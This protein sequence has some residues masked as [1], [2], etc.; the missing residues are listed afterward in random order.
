[1]TDLTKINGIGKSSADKIVAAGFADTEALAALEGDFSALE[2]VLQ[3]PQIES[4]S[5]HFALESGQ[6]VSVSEDEVTAA[7][8]NEPVA[9]TENASS[10]PSTSMDEENSSN[11]SEE[12]P[13]DDLGNEEDVTSDAPA[14]NVDVSDTEEPKTEELKVPVP[15]PVPGTGQVIKF[16]ITSGPFAKRTFEWT[17]FNPSGRW[18]EDGNYVSLATV[19]LKE[20]SRDEEV[21][22]FH[23]RYGL[24]KGSAQLPIA[25]YDLFVEGVRK[26]RSSQ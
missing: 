7:L 14:A 18:I 8:G 13:Q 19:G 15:V 22:D 4:L 23:F 10:N 17:A 9:Q 11:E 2:S 5:A 24:T 25:E 20:L 26:K 12:T 1:M 16:T 6:E 21:V 3:T